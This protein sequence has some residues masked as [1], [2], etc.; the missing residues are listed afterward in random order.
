MYTKNDIL[1]QLRALCVPQDRPVMLHTSLRLVGEVEGGGEGLLDAL[2]THVS[3]KGGLLCVAAHTWNNLGKSERYTLDLQ[4][5][6]KQPRRVCED[7]AG[8]R[9]RHPLGKPL[10]RGRGVR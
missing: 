4:K 10:T 7:R 9:G 5:K 8:A 3:A 2:I 1:A 6:G